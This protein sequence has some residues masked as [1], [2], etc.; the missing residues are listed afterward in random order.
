MYVLTSPTSTLIT[1]PFL[2]FNKLQTELPLQ[3]FY[4]EKYLLAVVIYLTSQTHSTNLAEFESYEKHPHGDTSYEI[5]PNNSPSFLNHSTEHG[6]D[7][8]GYGMGRVRSAV[9]SVYHPRKLRMH[10]RGN[11]GTANRQNFFRQRKSR[12]LFFCFACLLYRD[13]SYMCSVYSMLYSHADTANNDIFTNF[14]KINF[15]VNGN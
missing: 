6:V 15:T 4:I 10:P 5:L 2:I 13:K 1:T 7:E 11:N 12:R 8:N 9:P 3:M 14:K